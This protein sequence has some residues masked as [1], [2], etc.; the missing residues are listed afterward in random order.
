M[1]R[2]IWLRSRQ[3]QASGQRQTRLHDS[4]PSAFAVT[5]AG[6]KSLTRRLSS[7]YFCNDF[8]MGLTQ[9]PGQGVANVVGRRPA[10]GGVRAAL[11]RLLRCTMIFRDNSTSFCAQQFAAFVGSLR[12]IVRRSNCQFTRL[13]RSASAL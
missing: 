5:D 3:L 13:K 4:L 1:L 2:N 7:E 12:S 10:I 11:K 6:T 9:L 8:N